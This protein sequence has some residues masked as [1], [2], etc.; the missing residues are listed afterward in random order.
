L[1]D[2]DDPNNFEIPTN[3]QHEYNLRNQNKTESIEYTN[4]NL[5]DPDVTV[6]SDKAENVCSKRKV[7][8]EDSK[9]SKCPRTEES[10]RQPDKKVSAENQ[11][12]SLKESAKESPIP[13]YAAVVANS[14]KNTD[15][16]R[17]PK[18]LTATL[19]WPETRA[20]CYRTFYGPIL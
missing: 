6:N 5:K 14:P 13:S 2:G 15:K 3:T 8:A 10:S 16:N 12:H 18:L 19:K 9:M 20:Q 1:F 11:T 17:D 7:E 4:A